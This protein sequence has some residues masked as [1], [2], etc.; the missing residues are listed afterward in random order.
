MFGFFRAMPK[1]I[2]HQFLI[3]NLD[4]QIFLVMIVAIKFVGDQIFGVVRNSFE[5]Y[6][7]K[8]II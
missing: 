7:K 6:L 5:S 4:D 8:L 1:K 3:G 2:D